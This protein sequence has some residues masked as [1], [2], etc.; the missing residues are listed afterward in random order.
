MAELHNYKKYTIS[1]HKPAP[2]YNQYL[3]GVFFQ[4]EATLFEHEHPGG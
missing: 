1:I 2:E 3:H 4:H